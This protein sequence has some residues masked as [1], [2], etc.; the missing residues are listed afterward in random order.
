MVPVMLEIVFFFLVVVPAVAL[1]AQKRGIN[2]TPYVVAT[3]AGF[4]FFWFAGLLA[5]GLAALPL[6]WM[7][8]GGVF[9]VVEF[10]TSRGRKAAGTWRCPNC[11]MFNDLRTLVCTCGTPYEAIPL[12]GEGSQP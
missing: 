2:K 1:R 7:W 12:T 9:F 3:I 4:A 5:L 6:R 8:I 10:L 11:Q